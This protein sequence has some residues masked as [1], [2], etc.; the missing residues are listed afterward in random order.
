MEELQS[1]EKFVN[2]IRPNVQAERTEIARTLIK[3]LN[4]EPTDKNVGKIIETIEV[5]AISELTED[6]WEKLD[7]T[8]SFHGVRVGHLE[9]AEQIT[10]KHNQY[11]SRGYQRNVGV[12]ADALRDGKE[13]EAPVILKNEKGETH[14]VSGNTRLMVAR[15]LGIQPQVIVV[16]F[17]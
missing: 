17:K 12:L 16:E 11:L 13:M 2:W 3:F 1:Q 9:D 4:V 8:E 10:E 7:N 5:A 6:E 14:L 15:A